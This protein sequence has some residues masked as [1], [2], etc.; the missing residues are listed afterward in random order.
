MTI[1][2]HNQFAIQAMHAILVKR[3]NLPYLP[4]LPLE[5]EHVAAEAYAMADAMVAESNK[6]TEQVLHQ[7]SLERDA[8]YWRKLRTDHLE[9]GVSDFPALERRVQLSVR[10]RPA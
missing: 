1:S 4:Y 8:A 6:R 9:L 10:A 2:L 5:R 3:E 7:N